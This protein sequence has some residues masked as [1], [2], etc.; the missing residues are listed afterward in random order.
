MIFKRFYSSTGKINRQETTNSSQTGLPTLYTLTSHDD[1]RRLS[2]F[3]RRQIYALNH[4]MRDLEQAQ[5]HEF[6][7]SQ[8]ANMNKQEQEKSSST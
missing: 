5:F 6:C 8:A 4:L 1:Q 7:K 3:R 2:D